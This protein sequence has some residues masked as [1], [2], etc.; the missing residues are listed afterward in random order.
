L[1][2]N[3]TTR[4]KG[5]RVKRRRKPT[6]SVDLLLIYLFASLAIVI[7]DAISMLKI[8][9]DAKQGICIK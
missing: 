6:H 3:K 2:Y 9:S 4:S 1:N 7:A 8:S 5:L